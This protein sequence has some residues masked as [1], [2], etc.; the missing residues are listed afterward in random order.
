MMCNQ[1][2]HLP[3]QHAVGVWEVCSVEG[4]ECPGLSLPNWN[5]GEIR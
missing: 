3:S 4:C 1:C 5:E 2:G